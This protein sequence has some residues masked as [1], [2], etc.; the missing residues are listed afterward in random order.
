[1]KKLAILSVLLFVTIG[2]SAQSK[3]Q[4]FGTPTTKNSLSLMYNKGHERALM[5]YIKI[6]P[7][8]S[9]NFMAVKPMYDPDWNFTGFEIQAL[10]R[11]GFGFSYCHYR[12]IVADSTMYND[13]SVDLLIT[14]VDQG[15]KANSGVLLTVSA[16]NLW[17]L[18]PSVGIGL[19]I[20]KDAPFKAWPYAAFNV[21][22]DF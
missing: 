13:W 11:F 5:D 4:G 19:D 14:I 15:V 6:R 21:R 22:Y 8:M 17:N 9:A 10:T 2:L 16:F 20:I 18:K 12:P 3:W 1:M 7:A